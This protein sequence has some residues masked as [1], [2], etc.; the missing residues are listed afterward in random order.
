VKAWGAVEPV[1]VKEGYGGEA[2]VGRR[3]GQILGGRSSFEEG[4]GRASA[5][6]DVGRAIHFAFCSPMWI[7]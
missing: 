4:E 6:L 1:A 5:E 2:E 3:A 7:A